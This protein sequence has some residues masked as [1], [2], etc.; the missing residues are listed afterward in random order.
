MSSDVYVRVTDEPIHKTKP[1]Q[2]NVIVDYDMNGRVVGVEVL[3]AEEVRIDG[4]EVA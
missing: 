4:K 2:G 3:D 1:L